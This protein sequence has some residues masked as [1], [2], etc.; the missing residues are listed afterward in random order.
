MSL[1]SMSEHECPTL[2]T[3]QQRNDSFRDKEK[4]S[5]RLPRE[6]V[7]TLLIGGSHLRNVERRRLDRS[8]GTHVRTFPGATVSLSVQVFSSE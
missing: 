1:P 3:K 6:F 7:H 4:R 2:P 5:L 8:G